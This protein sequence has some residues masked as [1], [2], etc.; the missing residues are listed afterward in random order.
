MSQGSTLVERASDCV[1][2]RF[3]VH[4]AC[5]ILVRT[6]LRWGQAM[7]LACPLLGVQFP[8]GGMSTPSA[9]LVNQV[10][11]KRHGQSMS[12]LGSATTSGLSVHR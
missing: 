11:G 2:R 6:Q 5:H 8:Q 4:E 10:G 3:N 7:V 9:G 1:N 12:M